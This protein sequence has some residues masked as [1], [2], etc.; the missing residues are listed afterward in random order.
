MFWKKLSGEHKLEQSSDERSA[1]PASAAASRD[2]NDQALDTLASLM[3]SFGNDAFDTEDVAAEQTRVECEAWAQRL[4]V[5]EGRKE[6]ED[7]LPF[8]RDWGGLR[9]YFSAHRG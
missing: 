6:G 5:G 1:R 9:R 2:D 7:A 3:R 4:T 8:K